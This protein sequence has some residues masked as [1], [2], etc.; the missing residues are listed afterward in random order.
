ME[1]KHLRCWILQGAIIEDVLAN[2]SKYAGLLLE[3][4]TV[5]LCSPTVAGK[6]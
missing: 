5:I 1:L 6:E 3:M 2:R 4:K